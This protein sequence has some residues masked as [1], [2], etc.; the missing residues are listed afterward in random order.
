MSRRRGEP[1]GQC[2]VCQHLERVRVELL[3][4]GGASHRAVGK[5]YGLSHWAVGRHMTAHVSPERK[6]ALVLGPVSKA[7]LEARLC[8]ESESL[9]DHFKV[10]RA[11]LLQAYDCA[12]TAGD[13]H[14]IA[15]LARALNETNGAIGK[16]TGEILSSPLI[17][18]NTV[19]NVLLQS[20]PAQEFFDGLAQTLRPYPEALQQVV[21]WL[22]S[23]RPVPALEAA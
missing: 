18:N 3:V 9:L 12:I 22:E 16:M 17:Q 19:N 21:T 20:A 14:T 5:K 1:T 23:Q 2:T 11:G 8:E 6:A 13:G 7:A 4:V 10:T 15:S